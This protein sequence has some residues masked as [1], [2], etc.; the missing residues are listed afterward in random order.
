MPT[1]YSAAEA[2]RALSEDGCDGLSDAIMAGL[3]D[4]DTSALI[5]ALHAS[6]KLPHDVRLDIAD[7]ALDLPQLAHEEASFA[8][9]K[10][11]RDIEPANS[12]EE[13][14]LGKIKERLL[15]RSWIVKAVLR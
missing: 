4:L 1:R 8:L 3:A 5:A 13:E 15:K 2:L 10:M 7:T 12:A 11:L 9:A 14:Q 6:G